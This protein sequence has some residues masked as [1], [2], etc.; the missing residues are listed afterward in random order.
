MA[1]RSHGER[2]SDEV[3]D[4]RSGLEQ[5]AASVEVAGRAFT[6]LAECARATAEAFRSAAARAEEGA[7]AGEGLDDDAGADVPPTGR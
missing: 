4:L 1:H 6:L 7:G 3:W 2:S 5:A